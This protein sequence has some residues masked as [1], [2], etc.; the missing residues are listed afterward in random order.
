MK[1]FVSWSGQTSREIAEFLYGW[2]PSV[3]QAIEPRTSSADTAKGARWLDQLDRMLEVESAILCLT[4]TNLRSNSMSFEAGALA[5]RAAGAGF[6]VALLY[7]VSPTQIEGPLQQFRKIS[8]QRDELWGLVRQMN[9]LCPVPVSESSLIRSFERNYQEVASAVDMFEVMLQREKRGETQPRRST[10]EILADLL[11]TQQSVSN[12][13]DSIERMLRRLPYKVESVDQLPLFHRRS[14]AHRSPKA[15][16]VAQ[17]VDTYLRSMERG[18][19]ITRHDFLHEVELLY[20][21]E[22]KGL[23]QTLLQ[24]RKLSE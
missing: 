7:E 20:G 23:A 1:V 22:A 9:S 17:L 4:P 2:L 21:A 24:E 16:Q 11:S 18:S 3:V 13:L 10:D 5:N 12:R 8:F 15:L 6:V 14:A 19:D